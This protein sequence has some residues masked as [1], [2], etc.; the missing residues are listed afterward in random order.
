M[1]KRLRQKQ[2]GRR[3]L[4]FEYS[5][6]TGAPVLVYRFPNLF[7]KWCR[8]NYN[9]AVATFCHNIANGLPIT[10]N[11]RATELELLYIDDLVEEMLDALEAAPHRCNYDGL[12]PVPAVD[13]RYCFAPVTHKVTLG[14]IV[15]LLEQ[16]HAQPATL[17]VPEIPAGSFAEKAVFHLSFLPA[18]RADC[19]PLKSQ[20]RRA[21]QLYRAAENRKLRPVQRE[22]FQARH[23]QGPALAQ[24]QV[25][26]FYCGFPATG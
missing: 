6:T 11:D 5:K 24:H 16:F 4:F 3:R 1:A 19:L 25:G 18:Q 17:V 26:I 2:A 12:T 14:E 9:S 22:H 13:G 23:Y 8:P 20:R 10:V 21:R 7:G 15:D